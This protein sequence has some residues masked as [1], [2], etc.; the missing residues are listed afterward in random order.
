MSIHID[1]R[2][3]AAQQ[4]SLGQPTTVGHRGLKKVA[5]SRGS[6]PD[7]RVR[8]ML[9]K[10]SKK[11]HR[12]TVFAQSNA[13]TDKNG[14][15]RSVTCTGGDLRDVG[16]PPKGGRHATATCSRGSVTLPHWSPCRL[17]ASPALSPTRVRTRLA[18]KSPRPRQ[19]GQPSRGEGGGG[20]GVVVV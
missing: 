8:K 7:D 5:A 16:Q 9:L 15:N 1:T 17:L 14:E 12:C 18:T 13:A 20:R 11:K 4:G 6:T 10:S 2:K 3:T 19:E